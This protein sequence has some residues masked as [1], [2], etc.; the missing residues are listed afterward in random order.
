M[1]RGNTPSKYGSNALG[2]DYAFQAYLKGKPDGGHYTDEEL[3]EIGGCNKDTLLRWLPEWR[4]QVCEFQQKAIT[5]KLEV[6]DHDLEEWEKAKETI[7]QEKA[8][9][10]VELADIDDTTKFLREYLDKVKDHPDFDEMEFRSLS[11]AVKTWVALDKSRSSK[12]ND[13]LKICDALD[14]RSPAKVQFDTL[15]SFYQQ[16]AKDE[17]KKESSPS[18]ESPSE[19]ITTGNAF[20]LSTDG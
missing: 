16:R 19:K 2:K 12:R 6:G 7:S 14:K 13:Y 20:N 18:T 5:F 8:K 11:A 17:A 4:E 15:H 3:M 9:L 1:P 10:E